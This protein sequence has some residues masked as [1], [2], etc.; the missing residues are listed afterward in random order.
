MRP[1][2]S[3]AALALLSVLALAFSCAVY[4]FGLFRPVAPPQGDSRRGEV[5]EAEYRVVDEVFPSRQ[6]EDLQ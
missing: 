1:L 2:A 6:K 4:L 5:I 3:I